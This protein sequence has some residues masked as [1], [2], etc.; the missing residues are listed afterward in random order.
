[1]IC[2]IFLDSVNSKRDVFGASTDRATLQV[3]VNGSKIKT[4]IFG[5]KVLENV[6]GKFDTFDMV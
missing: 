3:Y 4:K 2:S 1:M 5:C 6:A